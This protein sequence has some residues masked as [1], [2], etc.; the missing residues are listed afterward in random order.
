MAYT[1]WPTI[2]SELVP[3]GRGRA[4]ASV[5]GS[6][7]VFLGPFCWLV[8]GMAPGATGFPKSIRSTAMSLSS[9]N[10]TTVA[11]YTC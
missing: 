10:P 3:I 11:G 5:M 7:A 4:V 9:S 8:T 6:L 2:R 1:R